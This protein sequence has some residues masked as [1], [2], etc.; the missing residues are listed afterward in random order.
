VNRTVICLALLL[1]VVCIPLRA[2]VWQDDFNGSALTPGWSGDVDA[3]RLEE[4]RLVG[5]SAHPILPS[6]AAITVGDAWTHYT[7]TVRVN[8]V[9]PNLAICSKGGLVL[10]KRNG[11]ALVFCLHTPSKQAEVFEWFSRNLRLASPMPL[12]YDEWHTLRVDVEARSAR[13]IVDRVAIGSVKD[14][15]LSG[16]V[17]VVVED[18]MLTLF[19]DFRVSGATIPNGGHGDVASVSPMGRLTTTWASIKR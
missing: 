7:A 13:F 14:V 9:K 5:V 10:G 15:D 18:T 1:S 11:W 19:D 16:S 4:N 3:F 8:V 17:G 6:L 2:G 12:E